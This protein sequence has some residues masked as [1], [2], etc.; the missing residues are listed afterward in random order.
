MTVRSGK[1]EKWFTDGPKEFASKIDTTKN[2][3]E[4]GDQAEG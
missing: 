1:R 2:K 3:D 4:D